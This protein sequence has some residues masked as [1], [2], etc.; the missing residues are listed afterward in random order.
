[1]SEI[2]CCI[3]LNKVPKSLPVRTFTEATLAECHSVR[4]HGR[5]HNFKHHKNVILPDKVNAVDGY[6]VSCYRSFTCILTER[7]EKGTS[8]TEGNRLQSGSHF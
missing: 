3:H 6:H 7:A 8:D 2:K 4:D 5:C 1:M